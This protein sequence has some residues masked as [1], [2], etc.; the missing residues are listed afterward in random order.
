MK[1]TDALRVLSGLTA[2]Q[3]GMVTTAQAAARGVTRMDLSRLTRGGHLE[4]LGHGVYRDAGTPTDRFSS[5]KTAWLSIEPTFTADERLRAAAS[6]AVVSGATAA[7]V[8]GLGDLVP[9]PY[10]FTVR[11]RRQTQRDELVFNTGQLT[12]ESITIRDG[13]P[14]TTPEQT[15][16]DLI[17]RRVDRTLVAGVLADVDVFDRERLVAL[18]ARLAQR[19]GFRRDDGEAF[20]AD[21]E[22]LA[23][24]DL[25]SLTKAMLDA[26]RPV[27]DSQRD[28]IDSIA[29]AI[30]AAAPLPNPALAKQVGRLVTSNQVNAAMP[31]GGITR[32]DSSSNQKD[33]R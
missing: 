27:L 5:V 30:A 32:D 33:S 29:K 17:E 10:E 21:L 16:A 6:D 25:V 24:R 8:L 3:W 7:F 28:G 1:A 26:L 15:I 12:L 22:R 11:A 23:G 14:V 31:A 4:R 9:E 2:S 13:L 19:N 18:L 20:V